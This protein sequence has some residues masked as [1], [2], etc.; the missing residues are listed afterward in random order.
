MSTRKKKK[1]KRKQ[2]RR[3]IP[4]GKKI[5]RVRPLA[6]TR[7]FFPPLFFCLLVAI[8]LGE[9]F[10]VWEGGNQFLLFYSGREMRRRERE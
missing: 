1:K 2:Q 10:V 8:W 7:V 3:S 6:R 9:L 4:I 5:V